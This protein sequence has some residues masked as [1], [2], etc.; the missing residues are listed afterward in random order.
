L[1]RERDEMVARR[2]KLE[3]M[4]AAPA[5]TETRISS[6]VRR[7]ADWLLGRV[8]DGAQADDRAG[9]DAQL[10]TD[11]HLA[12]AAR[13]ALKELGPSIERA[14]ERHRRLAERENEFLVRALVELCG[15][16]GLVSAYQK[17]IGELREIVSLLNGLAQMR[18]SFGCGIGAPVEIEFPTLGLA[19]IKRVPRKE[20][21]VD[22]EGNV[23]VWRRIADTMR[24]DPTHKASA[25]L[26][27][28]R[29]CK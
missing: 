9:L 3:D 16:V 13:E 25:L 11:R 2:T 5:A 10:A 28:P 17:K 14:E 22:R 26:S 19:A 8:S 1:T 15:E 29:S 12:A 7:T 21:R 20:M 18:G 27:L 6:I 4:V 24:R 23:S